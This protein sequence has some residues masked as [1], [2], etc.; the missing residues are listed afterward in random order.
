[1]QLIFTKGLAKYDTLLIVRE[2]GATER[3][4]CPKQGIIPHDMVHFA[5]EQGLQKRG[6]IS[7]LADGEAASFHM[8]AESESDGVERLV[9]VF[10]GD[11]W[12]GNQSSPEDLIAL[13]QITC[14]ARACPALPVES[15]D[16]SAIRAEIGFLTARWR[17]VPPGA[18]LH[19]VFS[20]SVSSV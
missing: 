12:S 20:S 2:S 3:I 7:R 11:A 18:S 15:G 1:M 6:F 17:A 5:V 19:L 13:Y 8:Q 10:Q 4:D 14:Q 9:E 16:I